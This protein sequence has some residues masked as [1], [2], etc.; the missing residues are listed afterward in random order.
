MCGLCWVEVHKGLPTGWLSVSGDLV[1]SQAPHNKVRE[2]IRKMQEKRTFMAKNSTEQGGLSSAAAAKGGGIWFSSG[3]WK[4]H[5]TTHPNAPEKD[6]YDNGSYHLLII[7]VP[8][9]ILRYFTDTTS[10][11][12]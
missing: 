7:C 5:S 4:P 12:R 10:Q 1:S 8:E 9:P 6:K 11:I 2:C 3:Q